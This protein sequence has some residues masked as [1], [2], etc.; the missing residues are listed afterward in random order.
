VAEPYVL[1]FGTFDEQRSPRPFVLREGL[2]ARGLAVRDCVVP[3]GMSTDLRV[4]IFTQPWLL[5]LFALRLVLAWARLLV[6]S[7]RYRRP[8]V[9]VVGYMA[10]LDVVLARAR[11]PR[12][13]VVM[14]YLVSLA[15]TGLDR[16]A[17]RGLFGRVLSFAD[18][19]AL[20]CSTLVV[21]DTDEHLAELPTG[22]R[23][24]GVVVLVG[25]PAATF[26]G[27][28]DRIDESP[29]LRVGF[30]GRYI[31]LQGA[32][33]IGRAI[34]ELAARQRTDIRFTMVGRGQDLEACRTA[35]A[36]SPHVTWID[37]M[38]E[39]DELVAL[40]ADHHVALGVFGTTTKASKIVP[41]KAFDAMA[42]GQ[43]V[44]TADTV[45]QRRELV[46]GTTFVQAGDPVAIADALERLADGR[47]VTTLRADAAALADRA[48][49]PVAVV[50]P[51]VDRLP[52]AVGGS[53]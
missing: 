15:G 11:Y 22:S 2:E 23:S 14:D 7:V 30:W 49:R 42:M 53:S 25:A 4:L 36:G 51:L 18:R 29:P 21:V 8:D 41:T 13:V 32:E 17:P 26:A 52:A 44:V 45:P 40:V 19:L 24:K 43:A 3:L 33:V 38:V 5:P 34:G 48:F 16:G 20:R 12:A 6:R 31:P 28:P 37:R 35:A 9:V 47:T 50:G 27:R 46:A 39:R 1:F 10:Q